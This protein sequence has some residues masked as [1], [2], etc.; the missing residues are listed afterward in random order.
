MKLYK[1][2]EINLVEERRHVKKAFKGSIKQRLLKLIDLFEDGNFTDCI[3]L[4]GTFEYDKKNECSEN[5][6]INGAIWN[7]LTDFNEGHYFK[8][9]IL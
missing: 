4:I 1:L 2:I 5:E 6:Y 3:K 8:L 7:V 9:E